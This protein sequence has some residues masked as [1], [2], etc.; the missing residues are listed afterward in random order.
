MKRRAREGV[1]GLG[2]KP[3]S[4]TRE[5]SRPA[6]HDRSEATK[7]RARECVEGLRAKP[8]SETRERSRRASH[9]RSE[10]T[11]R[12]S[13]RVCRGSEGEAP[14]RNARAK[15]TRVTRPERGDE[16]PSERVCRGSGGEAPRS[17]WLRGQDLNLRPLGYEP[18]ELPDCSTPRQGN[19]IVTRGDEE[20]Q[21]TSS[22]TASRS[23]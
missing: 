7:R 4:K 10:A 11:K 12:P 8:L 21:R 18:N 3:L 13:E 2:A 23:P 22:A 14:V 17:I 19:L 1:G 15:P 20:G 9:D 6:S 5:R 16:A